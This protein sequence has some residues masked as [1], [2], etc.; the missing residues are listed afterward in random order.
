[1]R[2]P[3]E[4]EGEFDSLGRFHVVCCCYCCNEILSFRVLLYC[5][6]LLREV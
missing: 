2:V 5:L 6:Y 1:M 3:V 4:S